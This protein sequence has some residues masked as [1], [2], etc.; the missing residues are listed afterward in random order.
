MRAL[1]EKLIDAYPCS[2]SQ[3]SEHCINELEEAFTTSRSSKVALLPEQKNY[4]Q[5]DK[6][7]SA[8][9]LASLPS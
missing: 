5:Y 9:C 2:D 6:L 4:R 1:D 3:I 7:N 8:T